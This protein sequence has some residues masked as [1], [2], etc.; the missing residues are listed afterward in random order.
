MSRFAPRYKQNR[1]AQLRGFYYAARTGSISRAAEKLLL[2]QPSV[3]LQVKALERE[4]GVQL[5][6]R[7][8]PRIQLTPDGKAM[9]EVARP[10]VEGIEHLEETFAR[11][12]GD[13]ESGTVAIAAG[14]STLQ[15]ILPPYVERFVGEYPRVD[16]RLHNVTG[17]SG[18]AML[19]DGELDFAVGPMWEV[20]P[21]VSFYPLF[22]Y[23]PMLATCISHPL[24]ERRRIALRDLVRYPLIL[25]PKDH[26]STARFVEAVF[27][28]HGLEYDVKLEVGGYEVIKQYVRLNL[29]ISI[30][31]SHCI[32]ERDQL[33]RKSV[34]RYFPQRHYGLVLRKGRELTQT[35]ARFVKTLYPEW[36]ERTDGRTTLP[37]TDARR[38]GRA[39]PRNRDRRGSTPR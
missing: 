3:S 5:F 7:Q 36:D 1:L 39:C 27:T 37:A 16:V 19:R 24:A 21:D 29:G 17:K 28:E 30:M 15:Y 33:Y 20:P 6:E 23:E 12:R 2:S 25:P 34:K 9:L 31:M 8:G 13:A 26:G 14:G 38:R 11:R 4:F 22:T 35:A 10:L 18:L 32:T